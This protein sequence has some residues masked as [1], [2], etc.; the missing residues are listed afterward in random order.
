MEKRRSFRDMAGEKTM[1]IILDNDIIIRNPTEDVKKWIKETLTLRNPDFIKKNRMGFWTGNTPEYLNLYEINGVDYHIPFGMCRDFLYLICPESTPITS[2]FAVPQLVE[3][4]TEIPLYD[5]QSEAVNKMYSAQYG[6]LQAPA[7]SGKTQMGLALIQK[8]GVK[9]LWLTHTADLLS[10]S[11]K[12]AEKYID[13]NLFGTITAGKINIGVGITFATVQTM[14]NI[15]L[16]KY[17]NEWGVIIVDEC[18]RVAG[19]PT[20][21][22]RF[23]KVLNTL[24]APHK[25]GLSAT[26]HRADG[27][28]KATKALLGEVVH[29][30]PESVTKDYIMPVGINP[31]Y[32]HIPLT[33]ESYNTDGTLNYQNMLTELCNNI[34]RNQ[35]I[36]NCVIRAN[37]GNKSVLILSDRLEHLREIRNILP[38]WIYETSVIVSGKTPIGER[39]QALSDMRTGKKQILFA[40][41]A[42]AKEG[43][44]IPILSR[45]ILATPQKDFAVIT[46]A[47]GRIARKADGKENAICYDIIDN[48]GYCHRAFK[49]RCTTYK[50]H[51][52]YFTITE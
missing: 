22:T 1:N 42:L 5:Y 26:V 2:L 49:K 41:Y 37:T 32:S 35:F 7:G 18:H 20:Q 23:Y 31:Q 14:A 47:I 25:Y 19:T 8:Y 48:D 9:A 17:K 50:K 38:Q 27:L 33:W 13:K 21:M 28:I 36:A 16:S 40:T 51:N 39:E 24:S 44:D 34:E 12:R 46:Q 43:L 15:D 29:D 6:I 11:K 52:C 4:G 10:Q 30:I 45:L 3:Y